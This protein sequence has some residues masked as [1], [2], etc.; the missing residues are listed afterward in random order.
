[1]ETTLHCM[2]EKGTQMLRV[3]GRMFYNLRLVYPHESTFTRF[4]G[5]T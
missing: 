2:K 5:H 4:L 3:T 1:M